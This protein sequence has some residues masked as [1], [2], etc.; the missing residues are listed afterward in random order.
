MDKMSV[1]YVEKTGHVLGAFT[2]TADSESEPAADAVVGS[3]LLLR[4]PDDGELL[5]SVGSQL[6]KV[7]NVDLNDGVLLASRDY[8]LKDD[9]PQEGILFTA[10]PVSYDD[11]TNSVEVTL[12][13]PTPE[14]ITVSVQIEDGLS[15]PIVVAIDILA[16][17]D[18][19]SAPVTLAPGTYDALVLAPGYRAY[20]GTI[21]AT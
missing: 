21:T 20:F 15:Q 2:R 3:A 14:D 11:P 1:I 6:L 9:L 18:N 16:T 13:N 17:T 8:V 4:D 19:G 7:K 12:P 5:F 10:T